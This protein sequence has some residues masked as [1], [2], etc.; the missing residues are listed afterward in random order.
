M[1]RTTDINYFHW[2]TG[3]ANTWC[4]PYGSYSQ[5]IEMLQLT[6]FYSKIEMD[7]NRIEDAINLRIQFSP[8]MNTNEPCSILEIMIALSERC[9]SEIMTDPD[10]GDRTG[11]WFYSM[12]QSL[13]LAGMTDNHFDVIFT[14]T[15]LDKFLKRE[16]KP[17]GEGSLFTIHNSNQDFRKTEI[18]YQMCWY[19]DEITGK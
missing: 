4:R 3:I 12:I 7:R 5:L 19:L 15:T 17:N 6:P 1:E 8:N 10:I 11:F 9:E 13:G 18:W 16:F 2:I 14:I